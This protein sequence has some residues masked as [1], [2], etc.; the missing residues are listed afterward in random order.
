MWNQ[1]VFGIERNIK[2][3]LGRHT[4]R[5]VNFFDKSHKLSLDNPS[6]HRDILGNNHDAVEDTRNLS[7]LISAMSKLREHCADDAIRGFTQKSSRKNDLARYKAD[8]NV[9]YFDK[10]KAQQRPVTLQ[11]RQ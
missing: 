8:K 10:R 9:F 6:V 7:C 3:L 4:V 11:G 2:I 5:I 1:V